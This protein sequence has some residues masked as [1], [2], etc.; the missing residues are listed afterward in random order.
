MKEEDRELSIHNN[1]NSQDKYWV[2]EDDAGQPVW[3]WRRYPIN[4]ERKSREERPA[5]IADYGVDTEEFY[6]EI[7]EEPKT[8]RGLIRRMV[9]D[10]RTIWSNCWGRAKTWFVRHKTSIELLSFMHWVIGLVISA[11]IFCFCLIFT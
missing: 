8:N 7:N 4:T 11:V 1:R 5:S 10:G 9:Q 2:Q 3:V 6:E